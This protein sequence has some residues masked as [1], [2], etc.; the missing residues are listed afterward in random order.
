MPTN[1]L[2]LNK[3]WVVTGAGDPEGTQ[4]APV[5]SLFLR[6][7][8]AVGTSFYVKEAGSGSSG[9]KAQSGDVSGPA[10]ATNNA[11]ALFSGTSGKFLADSAVLVSSLA[12]VASPVFT[13]SISIGTTP[14]SQGSIRLDSTGNI[15]ARNA[16]NTNDIRLLRVASDIVTLGA[17]ANA[18][19]IA[20]AS[21][22][23]P[24]V[25]V[26][27]PSALTISGL[28]TA[29][30]VEVKTAN[31]PGVWFWN[32]SSAVDE[33]RWG[34]GAGPGATELTLKTLNDAGSGIDTAIRVARS[35]T[36][37]TEVRIG[38]ATAPMLA[39][40]GLSTTPLN[41]DNL[42]SGTVPVARLPGHSST[43]KTG[44]ADV[45]ALDTLGATTDITTL[46]ATT[47]GH[48]LLPKLSGNPSTFLRGDGVWAQAGGPALMQADVTSLESRISDLERR[49]AHHL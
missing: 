7:E 34:W 1:V 42:T 38:N 18:L 12:P 49:L 3:S 14:A 41:A 44:G 25:P 31:T 37:V 8:G 16:A 48:G 23:F 26:S 19:V 45:I 22:A 28:I 17:P 21:V 9:W 4:S 11:L 6:E 15:Y 29:T 32:T 20:G 35:G 43:H 13:G 39:V 47:A 30:D 5:G 33:R 27:G 40:G 36:F 46:N 10:I 24:A 2:V